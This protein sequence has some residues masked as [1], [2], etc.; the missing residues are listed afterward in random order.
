VRKRQLIDSTVPA[1]VLALVLPITCGGALVAL[2]GCGD[3]PGSPPAG[4]AVGQ[5]GD[6]SVRPLS[7]R[8]ARAAARA[9]RTACRGR[10]PGQVLDSHLA[11][12]R[13]RAGRTGPELPRL[14]AERRR[15]LHGTALAEV[16]ARIYSLSLP[17]AASHAGYR[18]CLGGLRD[19]GRS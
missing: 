16:A 2:V 1:G 11:R 12:A 9:G 13:R 5:P 14:V 3:D 6:T 4:E 15:E 18:G 17:P 7:P 8:A 19:G 10:R